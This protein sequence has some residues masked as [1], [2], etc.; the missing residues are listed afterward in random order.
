ML[1]GWGPCLGPSTHSKLCH[2]LQTILRIVFKQISPIGASSLFTGIVHLLHSNDGA[3]EIGRH[4]TPLDLQTHTHQ[5]GWTLYLYSRTSENVLLL[6]IICIMIKYIFKK[7]YHHLCHFIL[8][9][10]RFLIHSKILMFTLVLLIHKWIVW[11]H[12]HIPC[13]DCLDQLWSLYARCFW[14]CKMGLVPDA[15]LEKKHEQSPTCHQN[16]TS[17]LQGHSDSEKKWETRFPLIYYICLKHFCDI[18]LSR[19]LSE[20]MHRW[21]HVVYH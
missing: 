6:G 17:T 12:E 3:K 15:E 4:L 9:H 16:S 20:W 19:S 13:S 2:S 8:I 1:A 21:G 10:T 14:L 7:N 11:E 5:E 18:F